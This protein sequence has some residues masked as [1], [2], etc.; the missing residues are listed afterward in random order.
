MSNRKVEH[1]SVIKEVAL[2]AMLVSDNA[3]RKMRQH[4]VDFLHAEFDPDKMGFPVLSERDK[5]YYVI[6]GQ[7]RIEALKLWLGHGWESQTIPCRVYTGLGETQEADIFLRLNNTLGINVFEKFKVAVTAGR[8]RET[9]IYA[10]VEKCGLHIGLGRTPGSIS[11]VAALMKVYDRSNVPTL[12][13]TLKI[14]RD[15]FG[16]AGFEAPVIEGVGMLCQRYNGALDDNK[17]VDRLRE[18]RGGV[19][20]L[21]NRAVDMKLRTGNAKASCVAAAAVDIYNAGRGGAGKLPNWWKAE[22]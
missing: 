9:R 11:A 10:A 6:D 7:H 2:G 8:E 20:G 18:T 12:V 17:A 4:R 19:K 22:G 5:R 15:A 21:L 14:I 3:Q 1:Q 16:D 13:R